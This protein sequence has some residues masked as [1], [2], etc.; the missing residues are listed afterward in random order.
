MR[1]SLLHKMV[2]AGLCMFLAGAAM[3]KDP[4]LFCEFKQLGNFTGTPN[5]VAIAYRKGA[6]KMAVYDSFMKSLDRDAILGDVVRDTDRTLVFKWVVKKVPTTS[7]S[8]LA[9]VRY[10]ISW[11]KPSRRAK[12]V[13]QPSGI[14]DSYNGLGRCDFRK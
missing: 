1:T 3:A 13:G 11:D 7:G 9:N 4:V 10:R 14:P 6:S 8:V 5:E 12:I 2:T